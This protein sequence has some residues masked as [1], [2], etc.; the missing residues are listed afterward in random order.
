MELLFICDSKNKDELKKTIKIKNLKYLSSEEYFNLSSN[1]NDKDYL[2]IID[3]D[4]VKQ[5]YIDKIRESKRP[6]SIIIVNETMDWDKLIETFERGETFYVKPI[7]ND[8]FM[9]FE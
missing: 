7:K 1:Y 4:H 6:E 9:I 3:K 5:N 2:I 8:D